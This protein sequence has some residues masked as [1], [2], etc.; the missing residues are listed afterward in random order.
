M[1]ARGL[2][3]SA[4]AYVFTCIFAYVSVRVYPTSPHSCVGVVDLIPS[5]DIVLFRSLFL[6][7]TECAAL[8]LS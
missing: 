3:L 1:H 7:L 2:C 8:T 4:G 5:T 6:R